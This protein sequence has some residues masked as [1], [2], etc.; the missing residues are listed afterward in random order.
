MGT[1]ATQTLSLMATVLPESSPPGG[2]LMSQRQYQ[3]PS[4]LSSG[5]GRA[6]GARGY[7]TGRLGAVS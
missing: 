1:P 4:G 2:P 7:F 6:P 3:A 5:W